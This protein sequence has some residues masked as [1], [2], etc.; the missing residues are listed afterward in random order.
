MAR[1]YDK[2]DYICTFPTDIQRD[3]R[4]SI[5]K[6]ILKANGCVEYP[7]QSGKYRDYEKLTTKQKTEVLDDICGNRL[8]SL[9]GNG[10][11][12]DYWVNKANRKR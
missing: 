4:K 5:S 9:D 3:I 12:A 6:V 11:H 7:I 8:V 1:I 2:W 10:F